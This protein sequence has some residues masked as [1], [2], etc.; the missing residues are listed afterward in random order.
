MTNIKGVHSLLQRLIVWI[1][2]VQPY[3][4]N[5]IEPFTQLCRMQDAG[6]YPYEG[7]KSALSLFNKI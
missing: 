4:M 6:Y 1:N 3:S 7:H 2:C 5:K